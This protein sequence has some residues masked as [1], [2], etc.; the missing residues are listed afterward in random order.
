MAKYLITGRYTVQG[1][2]ALAKTGGSGRRAEVQQLVEA[3]GGRLEAFYF[4]FGGTDVV[5]IVEQ[6]DVTAAAAHSLAVNAAGGLR[7]STTLLLTPEEMDAA[8]QK[9]V[10]VRVPGA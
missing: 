1:T 6:P 3:L 9:S 8:C 5:A 7:L 10:G 4:A 2:K